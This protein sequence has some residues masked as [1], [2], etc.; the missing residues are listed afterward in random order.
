M[1]VTDVPDNYVHTTNKQH[2][3]TV[4]D[5]S[6]ALN[7]ARCVIYQWRQVDLQQLQACCVAV[8]WRGPSALCGSVRSHLE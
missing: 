3:Y 8:A 2:I 6:Q 1:Q 7:V 5:P 4:Q